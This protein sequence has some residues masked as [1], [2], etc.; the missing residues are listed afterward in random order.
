MPRT[1]SDIDSDLVNQAKD[2]RIMGHTTNTKMD[3][4]TV[5]NNY[6]TLIYNE[7]SDFD[8]ECKNIKSNT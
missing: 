3:H 6:R 8:K 2:E 7:E 4:P 5:T 1:S